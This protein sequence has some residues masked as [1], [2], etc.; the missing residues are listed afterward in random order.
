MGLTNG[1]SA[2]DEMVHDQSCQRPRCYRGWPWRAV[3]LV[4]SQSPTPKYIYSGLRPICPMTDVHSCISLHRNVH[5]WCGCHH[6]VMIDDRLLAARST[7][8]YQ[9]RHETTENADDK[10]HRD[11]AIGDHLNKIPSN[12]VHDGIASYLRQ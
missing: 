2:G 7:N 8:N 9:Y 3:N 11:S 4:C 1:T 5:L 12:V 10:K 6:Q